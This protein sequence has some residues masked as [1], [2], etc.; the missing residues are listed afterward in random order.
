MLTNE[1]KTV[2]DPKFMSSDWFQSKPSSSKTAFDFGTSSSTTPN[3]DLNS[4][5]KKHE[6]DATTQPGPSTNPSS[7]QEK[8]QHINLDYESSAGYYIDPFALFEI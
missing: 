2:L 5:I 1:G 3:D 4:N 6:D 8:P 7:H